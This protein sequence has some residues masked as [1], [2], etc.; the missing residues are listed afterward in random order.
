LPAATAPP[1]AASTPARC[2]CRNLDSLSGKILRVDPITGKGLSDNPF[3]NGDADSNRSKVY[4]YGLRN[5]F[6]FAF[7]PGTGTLFIGDVGWNT[8]EEIN[9]GRGQDFG[10]PYYEGGSGVS[11]KTG[12]YQD[13][14]EAQAFYNSG[15]AVTPSLWARPALG[16]R[17]RHRRRRT[18]TPARRIPRS[19]ATRCSSPTSATCSSGSCSSTPTA[20]SKASTPWASRRRVVEMTM[21]RDGLMYY[22]DITAERSAG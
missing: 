14:S 7:Q 4:D 5:P 18:S 15:Q 22:V 20:R 17:R 12:G 6:R 9:R 13:L 21:G 2:A 19:I 8:W 10:W 16:G 1:S 11:L 3:Y